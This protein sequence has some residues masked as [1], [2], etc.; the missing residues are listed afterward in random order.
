MPPVPRVNQEPAA[1]QGVVRC[2][3]RQLVR[4]ASPLGSRKP[5][6]KQPSPTG[7]PNSAIM[8]TSLVRTVDS[9]QGGLCRETSRLWA[10]CRPFC[11]GRS[12]AGRSCAEWSCTE[13]IYTSQI[14]AG[15]MDAKPGKRGAGGQ[16][17]R[18]CCRLADMAERSEG[19]LVRP[20][21]AAP[22]RRRDCS[23]PTTLRA[24]H[25][26]IPCCPSTRA[27][28]WLHSAA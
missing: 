22:L 15:R 25:R 21:T 3:Q 16:H 23:C 13:Q 7:Q 26:P 11:A 14:C 18:E 2:P 6:R 20:C 24:P 4:T 5:G 8:C 28:S 10:L 17:L 19:K 1:V 27:A 9:L 12:C